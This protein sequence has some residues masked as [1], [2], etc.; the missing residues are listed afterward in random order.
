MLNESSPFRRDLLTS[1]DRA[2]SAV[3]AFVT[4]VT[5]P[6]PTDDERIV[7]LDAAL[8]AGFWTHCRLSKSPDRDER[9]QADQWY[10][11]WDAVFRATRTSVDG[12]VALLVALAD[13]AAGDLERLAYLGAG[14]F[15]DLLRYGERP[16]TPTILD[17]LDRAA[18][19]N[20]NVRLAVRAMWWGDNDDPRTVER[21]TRFGPTY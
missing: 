19:D 10:W 20:D 4:M 1:R 8:V 9:A 6:N 7:P 11:A 21:F 12:V 3:V 18:H 5:V 17:E 15:E 13:A 14:P 16:P 2:C